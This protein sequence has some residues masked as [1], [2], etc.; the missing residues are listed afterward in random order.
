MPIH[1]L[2]GGEPVSRESIAACLIVQNEEERLADALSSVAFCDEIIVVDGGS[3]DRTRA[4]AEAAGATVL[5][6]PWPGYAAQ[7]N[8]AIDNARADWILE[9][10]ADERVS[11]ALR[12]SIEELLEGAPAECDLAL[13]ALRNQFLGRAIGPAAKYPAYRARL[14]RRGAYRHDESRSVHEGIQARARPLILKGDLEHLLAS[15]LRESLIDV[16][17]YARLESGRVDPPRRI[18][19][20]A[21]AIL[22]RP[23]A[24]YAYR[25]LIDQGW[26]DGWRGLLK[27]A[28]DC[29]SDALVWILALTAPQA[30]ARGVPSSS[31]DQ[32][33][34]RHH[35]GVPKVIAICDA[36]ARAP[37]LDWLERLAAA[38]VD[39][40]LITEGQPGDEPAADGSSSTA[41][42]ASWRP[43]GVELVPLKRLGP[44][45][46]LRALDVEDQI[47]S[48]DAVVV[49]GRRVAC[50]RRLAPRSI[51][52]RA[53]GI[54]VGMSAAQVSKIIAARRAQR[55]SGAGLEAAQV[56]GSA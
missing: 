1:S 7:R 19:S 23:A 14:F 17:R 52:P 25:T 55:A 13:F 38:G 28:L 40:A 11:N 8:F 47:R 37:V 31:A 3:T 46:L 20:A 15:S 10:D 18:S 51:W 33:F 29:A 34:G 50:A 6:N 30:R 36:S 26:R 42:R 45:S 12:A 4:I 53:G 27:I 54:R 32:H 39:A 49:V 56:G 43:N 21:R 22:V 2:Y 41:R 48:I 24:K 9:L 5:L 35:A 16:W 44:I